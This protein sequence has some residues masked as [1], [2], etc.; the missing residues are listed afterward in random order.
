VRDE[1]EAEERATPV[2]IAERRRFAECVRQHGVPDFPDPDANG[3]IRIPRR[4]DGR[5][6]FDRTAVQAFEACGSKKGAELKQGL[7]ELGVR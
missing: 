6:S 4:P 5:A 3:F 2:Q 1:D 7:D